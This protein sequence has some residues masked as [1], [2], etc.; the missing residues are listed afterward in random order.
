ME[1]FCTVCKEPSVL[2]CKG[3]LGIVYCSQTC[4]KKDWPKHRNLCKKELYNVIQLPNL[5]IRMAKPKTT[6]KET[7]P[8]KM[9]C[10]RCHGSD[11]L[12]IQRIKGHHRCVMCYSCRDAMNAEIQQIIEQVIRFGVDEDETIVLTELDDGVEVSKVKTSCVDQL[13]LQK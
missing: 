4:Q 8:Q 10:E 2:K 7:V 9:E 6:R 5:K 1:M 3:C 11:D 13:D 12:H